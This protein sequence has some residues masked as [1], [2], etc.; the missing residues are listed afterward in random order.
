[1][2]GH[3]LTTV[4]FSG[5]YNSVH[6][7]EIDRE[8]EQQAEY[9][10]DECGR[11]LPE[12]MV[13]LWEGVNYREAY[14]LY[15]KGYCQAFGWHVLDHDALIFDELNSPREYNFTTDRVFA[16]IPRHVLN[17]LAANH[18]DWSH[19]AKLVARKFTSRDG[20]ASYYSADL[21][22]WPHDLGEWDHNQV[23]TLLECLADQW[24]MDEGFE[25]F[26]HWCEHRLIEDDRCNGHLDHV[27]CST[28]P[29]YVRRLN[30]ADY[31]R[32][33]SRRRNGNGTS[34]DWMPLSPSAFEPLPLFPGR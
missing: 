34:R 10:Q 6:A 9:W 19:M 24:A 18:V 5:F 33:R 2:Q 28:S 16:Y 14:E 13:N 11:D 12:F 20:F 31:L 26:D 4:P 7:D 22:E 23:G 21:V 32:E 15:A 27:L 1:M 8:I 25:E 3:K 29:E 30:A 17:D